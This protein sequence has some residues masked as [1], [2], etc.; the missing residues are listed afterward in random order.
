MARTPADPSKPKRTRSPSAPKSAY[1]IVQILDEQGNPMLFDKNRIRILGV[2]R[3]AD[4]VL[5]IVDGGTHPHAVYLRG[6]VPSNRG[7]EGTTAPKL[8]SVA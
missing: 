2:E 5:E 8:A 4:K 1:F 7:N 6:V 3:N